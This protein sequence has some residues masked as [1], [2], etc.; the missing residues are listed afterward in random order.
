MV[1]VMEFLDTSTIHGL[2]YIAANKGLVRLFW[3]SVVIAGF[4]GAFILIQQSFSSWADSP[5]STT[6]ETRPITE[7][8][9]PNVT[10]CPP[11]NSFTSLNPDIVWSRNITFDEE[12]RKELSDYVP[13]AA[14][15][16]TYKANNREYEEYDEGKIKYSHWYKGISKLE[17]SQSMWTKAKTY[18]FLTTAT[19]GSFLTPNSIYDCRLDTKVV[20]YLPENLTVGSKFIVDLDYDVNEKDL[21]S[22]Y[23]YI[24]DLNLTRIASE[25]LDT[26]EEKFKKKFNVARNSSEAM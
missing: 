6:I 18:G 5:I 11:R 3:I 13:Y 22:F 26:T 19:N 1:G 25:S 21:F 10:V 8:D 16:V 7:I 23:I 12:Q 20:I 14:Y 9:F 15:D 4:T 24:E 17:L 2:S